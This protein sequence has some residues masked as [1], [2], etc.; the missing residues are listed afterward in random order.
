[1]TGVLCAG[2]EAVANPDAPK[3]PNVGEDMRKFG[4]SKL[5]DKA[6]AQLA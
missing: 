1:V 6:E 5:A 4:Y 3:K 2:A